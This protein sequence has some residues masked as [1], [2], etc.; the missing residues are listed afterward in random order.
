MARLAEIN[1]RRKIMDLSSSGCSMNHNHSIWLCVQYIRGELPQER[2]PRKTIGE[3]RCRF[4]SRS[5]G[6]LYRGV[7]RRGADGRR[8]CNVRIRTCHD[9]ISD[10]NI[11]HCWLWRIK[12]FFFGV[13]AC[14][15]VYSPA[16]PTEQRNLLSKNSSL[17]VI[18]R[19][20]RLY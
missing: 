2:G 10:A 14:V 19:L 1:R 17:R 4:W 11:V 20:N 6:P 18:A 15:C 9:A 3:G 16:F 5:E 8:W 7:C 12:R 13:R